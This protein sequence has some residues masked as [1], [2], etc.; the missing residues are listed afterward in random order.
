M[1]GYRRDITEVFTPFEGAG[2]FKANTVG[3]DLDLRRFTTPSN[4]YSLNACAGNATADAVEILEAVHGKTATQL[5]RLYVY[6]MARILH[7][8]LHRDEGTYIATCFEVLSRFGICAETYWPYDESK[9][10]VA[11]SLRAERDARAHKIHSYYRITALGKDRIPQIKQALANQCPVVFGTLVARD[12]GN[13]RGDAVLS[14]PQGE[15]GGGHA[16][17][18]VGYDAGRGAFI[19]KNSWGQNWGMDGFA[20]FSEDYLTW[21]ETWDLWV[22]F[23]GY[24]SL[25]ENT[26]E[27]TLGEDALGFIAVHA[28]EAKARTDSLAAKISK[29]SD[30]IETILK[31]NAAIAL[32]LWR[33]REVLSRKLT[34]FSRT[35]LDR[36]SGGRSIPGFTTLCKSSVKTDCSIWISIRKRK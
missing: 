25:G 6:S 23:A 30:Q 3:A 11:P 28:S 13:H 18:I 34:N 19:I 1:Y 26:M 15:I 22:P 21:N 14:I 33:V 16:M 36:L 4:Q 20:Y 8:D 32:D 2:V 27:N 10:F 31:N 29:K 9:V 17:I 7:Q 35:S 24:D 12:L 5:S